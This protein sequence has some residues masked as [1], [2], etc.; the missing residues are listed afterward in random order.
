M[1]KRDAYL[2]KSSPDGRKHICIDK[3]NEK[4]IFDFISADPARKKKFN[5]IIDIILRGLHNSELYGKEDINSKAKDVTAMKMFKRGQNARLYCKEQTNE[6]GIFYVIV[7]E[8]LPKKKDQ[9]VKGK[10]KTLI[11][12]VGSYVYTIIERR[13]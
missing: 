11:E 1:S 7:A 9:Q 6:N 2:I 4:I 13:K 12:I 8:L 3:L 10:T 5:H